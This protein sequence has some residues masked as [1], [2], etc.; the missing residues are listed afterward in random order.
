MPSRRPFFLTSSIVFKSLL[1]LLACTAIGG[2]LS[3]LPIFDGLNQQWVDTQIRQNGALGVGY[4]L[5]LSAG[6]MSIG[7]P[8]QVMAFLGGYAFGFLHGAVLSILGAILGCILSFF[9]S[10]LLLKPVLTRRYSRRINQVGNFLQDR[11]VIKTLI[12]RLLPL[13]NNLLTNLLVGVT[14]IKARHFILGSGLG[15]VP[16]M[17]LF[18][19]MGEGIVV[20]SVWKVGVSIITLFIGAVLS[21]Y[22]YKQYKYSL[23]S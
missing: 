2:L 9:V 18:A 21:A 14:K 4:F 15:Y 19:L 23:E 17:S 7:C 1:F 16:Q 13:G 12:I 3:V 20:L 22:L 5:L 6:A 8:R 11:P 10:R